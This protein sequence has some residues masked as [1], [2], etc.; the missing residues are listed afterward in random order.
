LT[1]Y[2]SVEVESGETSIEVTEDA[3][4]NLRKKTAPL[5]VGLTGS[6]VMVRYLPVPPVEDWRLERLMEFEVREIEARSGSPLATSFNLLPVPKELDEDDTVLLGLIK[7]ELLGEWLEACGKLPVQGFTPNSI[8]LYNAFLA[9]GDHAPSVTLLAN[10]GA[11]TIDLALVRGS[12]LY[13]ARSVTTGLDQ[14]DSTLGGRLGVD[15]LRARRLIHKHLDL[16]GALGERLSSDAERVT[17]PLLPLYDSMPTLLS[18]VI[19]LCKAQARLRD[20]SLDRILLTGGGALANGLE[21]FLNKRTGVP[22]E[23][24]NPVEMLDSDGLLDDQFDDLEADGTAAT[25]AIGLALSAADPELYALEVLPASARKKRDFQEKG[26]FSVIAAVLA[27]IFLLVELQVYSGQ[28]TELSNRSRLLSAQAKSAQDNDR[29]ADDLALQLETETKLYQELVARHAIQRSAQEILAAL[30][31]WL[32]DN[33]WVDSFE[34]GMAPGEDWDLSGRSVPVVTIRIRGENRA[35]R[36]AD[37]FTEFSEKVKEV[38]PGKE[39]AIQI[40]SK[41]RGRN[42]EW[43]LTAVLLEDGPDSRPEGVEE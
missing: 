21:E 39:Q 43:T 17:R 26:I 41:E 6:D 32:P 9:L 2:H 35:R 20:L 31:Q 23:V 14:R 22:V 4:G 3:F 12:E 10:I 24:W 1:R 42:P 15:S 33:L 29:I 34:V 5:R 28:A 25:V 30:E 36:A 37:A 7:E 27:V 16:R 18:G 19:T 8:A 38:L 40:A 13:F 11:G